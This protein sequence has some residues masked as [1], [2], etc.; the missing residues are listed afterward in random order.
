M[1][2]TKLIHEK[3]INDVYLMMI[4]L[5][6]HLN[7]NGFALKLNEE[8]IVKSIIENT[9]NSKFMKIILAYVDGELAGFINFALA[10]FNPKFI[11][12]N[13][14][15]I[16]NITELYVKQDFRGNNIGSTLL[17]EAEDFF[18]EKNITVIQVNTMFS[19]VD[20]IKFYKNNGFVEDYI[21]FIKIF[22]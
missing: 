21:A 10:Q 8:K 20:A 13:E 1:L 19:N 4:D 12:H 5:Y 2:T 15:F 6:E 3:D 17:K 11:K 9:V 22:D 16:G 14:K 7:K 18:K